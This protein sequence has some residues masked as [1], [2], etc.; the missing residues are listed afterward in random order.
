MSWE[1]VQ[2]HQQEKE[3]E[4]CKADQRSDQ[5]SVMEAGVLSLSLVESFAAVLCGAVSDDAA[6]RYPLMLSL[7]G[8]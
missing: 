8:V 5:G 4:R 1:C 3:G 2:T 7:L 6:R